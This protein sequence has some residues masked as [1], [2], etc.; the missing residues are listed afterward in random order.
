MHASVFASRMT[1]PTCDPKEL[2]RLLPRQHLGEIASVLAMSSTSL[3]GL[4]RRR[5]KR[6]QLVAR[7]D[8]ASARARDGDPRLVESRHAAPATVEPFP[9]VFRSTLSVL[10]DVSN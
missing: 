9:E 8:V 7:T 3:C 4:R 10:C 5:S 2:A 6:A 1:T